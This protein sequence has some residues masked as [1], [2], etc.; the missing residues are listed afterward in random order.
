MMTKIAVISDLHAN[1]LA[2]N[3]CLKEIKKINVDLLICLGDILTYG[4]KPNEVIQ[5]LLEY[6]K[7]LPLEINFSNH[8]NN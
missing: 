5:E 6:Q 1:A 3:M 4:T 7:K 8:K 2:L